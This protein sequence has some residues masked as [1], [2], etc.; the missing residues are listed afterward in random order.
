MAPAGSLMHSVRRAEYPAAWAW[1]KSW[2]RAVA[3]RT[4]SISRATSGDTPVTSEPQASAPATT[5]TAEAALN[6]SIINGNLLGF[7][8]GKVG[9]T[10]LA[11]NRARI[12][13]A[14]DASVTRSHAGAP[15]YGSGS[16]RGASAGPHGSHTFASPV[17]ATSAPPPLLLT[18]SRA[19]CQVPGGGAGSAQR[20]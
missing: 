19:L 10:P 12:A 15:A 13:R 4:A 20:R 7:D 1:A 9:A 8:C 18:R 14:G 6:L 11:I 3:S 16:P 5:I 2:K 17:R